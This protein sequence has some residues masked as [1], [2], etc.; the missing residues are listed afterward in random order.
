MLEHR[1]VLRQPSDAR[2]QGSGWGDGDSRSLAGRSYAAI[3]TQT[4]TVTPIR[5][6][7]W[8]TGIVRRDRAH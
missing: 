1:D 8:P 4:R 7:I 5:S 3:C 6:S 2:I